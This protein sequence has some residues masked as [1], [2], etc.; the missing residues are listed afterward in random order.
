M[1]SVVLLL[2]KAG[3]I[4]NW[5][6]CAKHISETDGEPPTWIVHQLFEPLLRGVSY[7]KAVTVRHDIR[8]VDI[9]L[10]LAESMKPE[11]IWNSQSFGKYFK[12]PR[13]RPYNR[14]A[15]DLNG[16]GEHFHDLAG[17]PLVFDRR[18]AEREAALIAR[19]TRPDKPTL[20]LCLRCAKNSPFSSHAIVGE[21][22]RRRWTKRFHIVD[23]CG[24]RSPRFYDLVGLMEKSALLVTTDTAPLHLATTAPSMKVIALVN[25]KVFL[26]S[27]CRYEPLLRLRYGEVLKRMA[28][29]HAA[30]ASLAA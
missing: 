20:L 16:F 1:K 13:D 8:R 7:V 27:E 17:W 26:G 28:D 5:L 2:A 11:K 23:I 9:A 3:D 25:D 12:G 18:D 14:L 10:K 15:W 30:I 24:V 6:A 21:S 29:V 22:I 19:H 4:C